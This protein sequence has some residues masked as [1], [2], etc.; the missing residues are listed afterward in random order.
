MKNT[1]QALSIIVK[2]FGPTNTRGAR[3]IITCPYLEKSKKVSYSHEYNG[4]LEQ[5]EALLL[6]SGIPCLNWI[7][8]EKFQI[9]TID[10]SHREK[11]I[12]FFGAK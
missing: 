10:W 12:S 6:D 8:G 5:I 2:Y 7:E 3:I 11:L 4:S 9:L 1:Y